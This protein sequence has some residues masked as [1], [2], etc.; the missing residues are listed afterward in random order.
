[1]A[2]WLCGCVAM[3]LFGYVAMWLRTMRQ[4]GYKNRKSKIKNQLMDWL[5]DSLI[6]HVL[7]YL[8]S[9][10]VRRPGFPHISRSSYYPV[11]V[12]VPYE[13][14]NRL[15]LGKIKLSNWPNPESDVCNQLPNPQKSKR[16]W[17]DRSRVWSCESR[18]PQCQDF[19]TFRMADSRNMQKEI[20][21]GH[22]EWRWYERAGGRTSGAN[23]V[24]TINSNV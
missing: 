14:R 1:M 22:L 3:W 13:S 18:V 7:K 11:R 17:L 21:P 8:F 5:S 12:L 9:N 19:S 16:F 10:L 2:I 4:Y 15:F 24:A 20:L 6:N 23:S